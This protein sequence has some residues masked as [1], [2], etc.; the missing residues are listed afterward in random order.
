MVHDE[1]SASLGYGHLGLM[2]LGYGKNCRFDVSLFDQDYFG[3]RIQEEVTESMSFS[4][5]SDTAIYADAV[6][7]FT[8]SES[9]VSKL[10]IPA[11]SDD[12]AIRDCLNK[13]FNVGEF[14]VML[15]DEFICEPSYSVTLVNAV[16]ESCVMTDSSVPKLYTEVTETAEFAETDST[17]LYTEI[18]ETLAVKDCAPDGF[19]I[20]KFDDMLFDGACNPLFTTKLFTSVLE[21]LEF[22]DLYNAV[23]QIAVADSSAFT[24]SSTTDIHSAVNDDLEYSES[25]TTQITPPAVS[26]SFT[27]EDCTP[28]G[29][30]VGLFD[31]LRFD[32][33]CSPHYVTKLIIPAVSEDL[34]FTDLWSVLAPIVWNES[35]EFTETEHTNTYTEI[36]EDLELP[37]SPTTKI[38]LPAV[39][40][41]LELELA[42]GATLF[43]DAK[44]DINKFDGISDSTNYVT[45]LLF[46]ISDDVEFTEYFIGALKIYVAENLSF[47]E[48]TTTWISTTIADHFHLSESPVTQIAC[49]VNEGLYGTDTG[50]TK[51]LEHVSESFGLTD[52]QTTDLATRITETLALAESY[53]SK[54]FA[55]YSEHMDLTDEVIYGTF[56]WYLLTGTITNQLILNGK[57]ER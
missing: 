41:T 27:L 9:P 56:T 1:D 18:T 33:A 44:F 54:L 32:L 47:T 19:D 51:I 4:D 36:D 25:L 35:I 42:A 30:D 28:T 13:G 49:I 57:I 22:T 23:L 39:S 43:D 48:S 31:A 55:E 38:I 3:D 15:F 10:K 53:K 8:L 29:F 16:T 17:N 24:D 26:E 34:E 14:D 11:V 21:T 50:I 45:K 5:S 6:D 37:E 20:G 12:F 2:Q 46:A 7:S 52:T 40:D